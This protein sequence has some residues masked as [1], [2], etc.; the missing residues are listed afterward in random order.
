MWRQH[1]RFVLASISLINRKGDAVVMDPAISVPILGKPKAYETANPSVSIMR[2]NTARILR[3]GPSEPA[4]AT[5]AS[6]ERRA[7][8]VTRGNRRFWRQA[9]DGGAIKV[10]GGAKKV[11]VVKVAG[12]IKAQKKESKA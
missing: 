6:H 4:G 2:V 9:R 12:D 5:V 8:W 11:S 10:K 1:V 3:T 7:H